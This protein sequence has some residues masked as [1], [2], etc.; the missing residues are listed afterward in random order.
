MLVLTRK[1]NESI[2]IGE[3]I[4][5]TILSA[6]GDRVRIGIDAPEELRIFRPEIL[7]KTIDENKLS[8]TVDT[9]LRSLVDFRVAIQRK[10]K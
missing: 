8:L 5:V 7:T 2:L 10:M 1:A 9:S 4:K 3:D 6:E